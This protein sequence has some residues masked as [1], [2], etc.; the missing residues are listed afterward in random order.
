MKHF[1]ITILSFLCFI[2]I[3]LSQSQ[4][5]TGVKFSFGSY[6]FVNRISTL[7]V[8]A[9]YQVS[10]GVANT[11][12]T[13]SQKKKSIHIDFL[14]NIAGFD[15][16]PE[17]P[18]NAESSF[19]RSSFLIPVTLGYT[20]K[21]IRLKTGLVNTFHLVSKVERDDDVFESN[22]TEIINGRSEKRNQLRRN[23]DLQGIIGL[24]YQVNDSFSI[25]LETQFYFDS[26]TFE[27]YNGYDIEKVGVNYQSFTFTG[28]YYL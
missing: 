16:K 18:F 6:G 12:F 19:V 13:D 20:L 14:Y 26:N 3:G 9:D 17:Q 25:G 4:F 10:F 21:K 24:L 8:V 27:F 1:C 7:E 15:F 11:Y 2:S 22:V 28:M 5:R 23:F